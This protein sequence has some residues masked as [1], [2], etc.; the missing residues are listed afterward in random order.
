MFVPG[1][2]LN[3]V[4]FTVRFLIW[5]SSSILRSQLIPMVDLGFDFYTDLWFEFEHGS[6]SEIVFLCSSLNLRSSLIPILGLVLIS[7]FGLAYSWSS[8]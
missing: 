4:C 5:I 2:I 8:T 3:G 6:C 1:I 7:M